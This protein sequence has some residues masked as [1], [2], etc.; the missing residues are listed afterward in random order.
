MRSAEPAHPAAVEV[1]GAPARPHVVDPVEGHPAAVQEAGEAVTDPRRQH[2]HDPD[3][4]EEPSDDEEAE[5]HVEQELL[6]GPPRPW[7]PARGGRAA[8][9]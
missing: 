7:L 5:D 1:E 4:R 3:E 9:W 2:A 8:R 6:V